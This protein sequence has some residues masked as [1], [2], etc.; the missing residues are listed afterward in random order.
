MKSC[1]PF[2]THQK[3]PDARKAELREQRQARVQQLSAPDVVVNDLR[4]VSGS[5]ACRFRVQ[6]GVDHAFVQRRNQR[7]QDHARVPGGQLGRVAEV[8]Q[9]AIRPTRERMMVGV[10]WEFVQQRAADGVVGGPRVLG[11]DPLVST[12]RQPLSK[13][14]V[15][16]HVVHRFQQQESDGCAAHPGEQGRRTKQPPDRRE[17]DH[18]QRLQPGH[19][20]GQHALDGRPALQAVILDAPRAQPTAHNRPEPKPVHHFIPPGR[21][22][23]G[24]RA[25]VPVMPAVVLDEK[26]RVQRG[27]QQKLR[28]GLKKLVRAMPQLMGHIDSNRAEQDAS[29]QHQS[30]PRHTA[31]RRH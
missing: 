7:Q 22:G 3:A 12:V 10:A 17:G 13:Q 29:A 31:H 27:Q 25:D 16:L 26:V 24:G 8:A 14:A 9:R 20:I 6:L 28:H 18:L 4:H 2:N 1:F 11:C 23:V 21:G 5:E 19:F 15:M 30:A